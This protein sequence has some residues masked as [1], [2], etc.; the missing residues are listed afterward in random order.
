MNTI[1]FIMYGLEYQKIGDACLAISREHIPKD[2]N[3]IVHRSANSE[4]N[5]Q[6]KTSLA[7]QTT[8]KVLYLDCDMVIQKDGIEQVF[9]WLEDYDLVLN[10]LLLW[11]EGDK[12][13]RIYKRAMQMF[14][15]SLPLD[16]WNGGFVGFRRSVPVLE[17]FDRWNDYWKK[18]GQGREMPPLCCA[19]QN[20]PELKVK[21][22]PKNFFEAEVLNVDA[23]VQHD[24]PGFVQW[25]NLPTWTSWKPFDNDARDWSWVEA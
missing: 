18:F 23:I 12:I 13:L 6:L 7:L 2:I 8:G 25:F 24:C 11:N 17:F 10:R 20:T 22:L 3:V 21:R 4:G 15:A 16:V 1:V 14:G 19:A 5:R 9:E